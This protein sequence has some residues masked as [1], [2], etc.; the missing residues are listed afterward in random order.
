VDPRYAL[1]ILVAAGAHCLDP[2]AYVAALVQ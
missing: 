1:G 2:G